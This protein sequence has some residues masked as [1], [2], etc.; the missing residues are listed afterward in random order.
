MVFLD[1]GLPNVLSAT[2]FI[3]LQT[4][5]TSTQ[6][7]IVLLLVSSSCNQIY[8]VNII[9]MFVKSVSIT[10]KLVSSIRG[11]QFYWW[12]KQEY[13]EKK[14]DLPQ[15]TVKLYHVKMYWVHLEIRGIRTHKFCGDRYWFHKH[16]DNIHFVYLIAGTRHQQQD[17]SGLCRCNSCL[18]SNKSCSGQNIRQSYV[19][20]YH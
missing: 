17:N 19:Q 20:K 18:Q 7:T 8:K 9:Y 13:P 5:I 12:R 14:T 10:T 3:G 4:T 16:I 1:V 2:W 15:V 11:S 6:A